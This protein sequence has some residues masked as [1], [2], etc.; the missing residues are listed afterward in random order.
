MKEFIDRDLMHMSNFTYTNEEADC[1]L[2]NKES[3]IEYMEYKNID[4]N[5][6]RSMPDIKF[7]ENFD[8]VTGWPRNGFTSQVKER[9][10][11]SKYYVITE[12]LDYQ[13]TPFRYLTEKTYRAFLY[14]IPFVIIGNK[15]LL[16]YLKGQGYLVSFSGIG[17]MYNE[18]NESLS[19]LGQFNMT[20]NMIE[21][22][23]DYKP[24]KA[25]LD[26][27][28]YNFRLWSNRAIL[29]CWIQTLALVNC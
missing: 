25:D 7:N 13:W 16:S 2:N 21:R 17:T 14:K 4:M 23:R 3:L 27:C 28:E 24:T 1:F 26:L 12:T 6:I 15:G 29:R 8:Q 5:T 11:N 18:E 9:Y 20:M 10:D 22:L 19:D